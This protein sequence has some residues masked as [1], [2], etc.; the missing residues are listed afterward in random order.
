MCTASTCSS[1]CGVSL[2]DTLKSEQYSLCWLPS[3]QEQ[4]ATSSSARFLIV[5]VRIG[6]IRETADN[7]IYTLHYST[8]KYFCTVSEI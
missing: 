2:I 7:E 4:P 3:V 1:P 6:E 5:R 8:K